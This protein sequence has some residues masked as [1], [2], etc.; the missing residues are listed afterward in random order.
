[1]VF[2]FLVRHFPAV[3]GLHLHQL[4]VV[5]FLLPLHLLLQQFYA[6]VT[7]CNLALQSMVVG[8]QLLELAAA[9]KRTDLCH[10]CGFR[11][12]LGYFQFLRLDFLLNLI[13]L[14]FRLLPID[15]QSCAERR[16][17]KQGLLNLHF[18]RVMIRKPFFCFNLL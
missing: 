1:M 10:E 7:S 3:L 13:K 6:L 12:C 5:F 4:P 14:L 2:C 11:F 18:H 8:F 17:M 15:K 16:K 9:Q